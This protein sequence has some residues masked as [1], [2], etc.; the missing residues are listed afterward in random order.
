MTEAGAGVARLDTVLVR[1]GLARSRTQAQALVRDG[2]VHVDGVVVVKPSTP[3]DDGRDVTVHPGPTGGESDWIAAGWVGRGAL[4]LEHALTTWEPLGLRVRDRRCLD[5]GASTGGFTQA[6]LRHGAAHVVALDVGHGQLDPR[7]A[8]HPDVDDL[9]G[10]N[11]RSTSLGTIGGPVGAAVVDVS[12]IS[13]RHVLAALPPLLSEDADVVLL[14]KP[15][16]EVGPERLARDGVVRSA[17][18]RQEALATVL[19]ALPTHGLAPFGL[20]RSPLRGAGGNVEYLLW[21]RPCRPGMM[22]WGLTPDDLASV[23]AQ[24]RAEE[25]T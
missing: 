21:A 13:A 15:Q 24:L 22:D 4:K 10:T 19:E 17:G 9:S 7:V 23:R 6:L 5:V 16:F 11:I 1:R 18:L 8:A 2:R 12:F 25:E 3:V 20:V 14:V